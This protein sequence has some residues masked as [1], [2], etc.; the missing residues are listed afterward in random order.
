MHTLKYTQIHSNTRYNITHYENLKEGSLEGSFM[1]EVFCMFFTADRAL[2]GTDDTVLYTERK[3]TDDKN[4]VAGTDS[5][6]QPPCR[7]Y[8]SNHSG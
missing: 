3:N 1:L 7:L 5:I 8:F 2:L 4:L 6:M